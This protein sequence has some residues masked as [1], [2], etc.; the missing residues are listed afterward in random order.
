M[1][2]LTAYVTG[3]PSR[4]LDWPRIYLICRR[5]PSVCVAGVPNRHPLIVGAFL[6]RFKE[7]Q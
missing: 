3:G 6:D 2:N 4:S 1:S 7:P 5:R